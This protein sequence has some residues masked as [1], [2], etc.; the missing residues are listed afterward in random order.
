MSTIIQN[1][2]LANSSLIDL[3]GELIRLKPEIQRLASRIVT[4]AIVNDAVDLF[5]QANASILDDD[6]KRLAHGR[7]F[8]ALIGRSYARVCDRFRNVGRSGHRDPAIDTSFELSLHPRGEQTVL[9]AF[10]ERQEMKDLL[11]QRIDAKDIHYQ[12][13]S[14]RPDDVTAIEWRRRRALWES[15]LPTGRPADTFLSFELCHGQPALI[16]DAGLVNDLIPS[17]EERTDKLA[18]HAHLAS[19][20]LGPDRDINDLIRIAGEYSTGDELKRE[21]RD[22]VR[23]TIAPV[24]LRGS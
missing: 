19:V 18:R 7:T 6:D 21:W 9:I 10:C 13:R 3:H 23:P 2:L 4:R 5:D 11:G 1:G 22:R 15:V 24:C 12:D 16:Y 20:E 8:D 14:D 17:D